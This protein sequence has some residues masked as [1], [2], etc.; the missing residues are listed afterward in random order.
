MNDQQQTTPEQY[1]IEANQRMDDAYRLFDGVY[2][3]LS[4]TDVTLAEQAKQAW[5]QMMAADKAH[6]A[7]AVALM[8]MV[9]EAVQ[10][11]DALYGQLAKI[12]ED[13]K[14]PF[15]SHHP[16][17][18]KLVQELEAETDQRVEAEFEMLY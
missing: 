1:Q 13:L 17:I 16:L 5:M 15:D 18:I 4:A 12:E 6:D 9:T 2:C 14:E 10:R 3:A 8:A 11:Y 7:R